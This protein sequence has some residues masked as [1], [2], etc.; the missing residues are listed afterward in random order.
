[1]AFTGM[2][3]AELDRWLGPGNFAPV[4]CVAI[5]ENILTSRHYAN[6]DCKSTASLFHRLSRRTFQSISAYPGF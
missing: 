1:V 5:P 2:I 4:G 6:D 3:R